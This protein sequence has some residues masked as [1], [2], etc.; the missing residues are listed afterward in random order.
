LPDGTKG[1]LTAT[2]FAK[3]SLDLMEEGAEFDFSE[4]DNVTKGAKGPMFEKAI[5]R[6]KKFGN[7]NVFILTAR[8]MAA[9]EPIH[10]FLKSIGLDIPVKNIVGLADGTPEA[11]AR[12]VVGKAAEGYNDFYFADDA[13]KNVKAVRN[14]LSIFLATH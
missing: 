4:F 3:Q 12:W 14:A 8:P 13:Y 9:A 11:K 10:K 6:N 5:A 2:Q 1:K 7:Q